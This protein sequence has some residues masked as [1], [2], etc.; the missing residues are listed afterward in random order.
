MSRLRKGNRFIADEASGGSSGESS[1]SESSDN[2]QGSIGT[3]IQEEVEGSDD[4]CNHRQVDNE[5]EEEDDKALEEDGHAWEQELKAHLQNE[6]GDE[7]GDSAEDIVERTEAKEGF[8]PTKQS[9]AVHRL[10]EQFV[11]IMKMKYARKAR[12][13]AKFPDGAVWYSREELESFVNSSGI[14]KVDPE[15]IKARE[16]FYNTRVAALEKSAGSS[17]QSHLHLGSLHD[18]VLRR[19]KKQQKSPE[20]KRKKRRKQRENKSPE[21][22]RKKRRKQR[23]NKKKKQGRGGNANE[24]KMMSSTK[25]E[26]KSDQSALQ[27]S[28]H[29]RKAQAKNALKG[30]GHLRKAQAKKTSHKHKRALAQA[31]QEEVQRR[32]DKA[33]QTLLDM[34]A[35]QKKEQ[36]G[37]KLQEEERPVEHS[38]GDEECSDGGHHGTEK[39][40]SDDGDGGGSV[41][42]SGGGHGKSDDGLQPEEKEKHEGDQVK[43]R[44]GEDAQDTDHYSDDG[45]QPEEKEQHER[46]QGQVRI[47]EDAQDTD[48]YSDVDDGR[49]P[50]EKGEHRK[51]QQSRAAYATANRKLTTIT[52]SNQDLH[53]VLTSLHE[54]KVVETKEAG[55]DITYTGVQRDVASALKRINECLSMPPEPG[56]GGPA[57]SYVA[58]PSDCQEGL[59]LRRLTLNH[60]QLWIC[61]HCEHKTINKVPVFPSFNTFPDECCMSDP[62]ML[63]W[64]GETRSDGR[65]HSCTLQQLVTYYFRDEPFLARCPQLCGSGEQIEVTQRQEL[66]HEEAPAFI[67]MSICRTF[68]SNVANAHRKIVREVH[69][70]SAVTVPI[71]NDAG[72]YQDVPYEIVSFVNHIG[73]NCNRGHY[74]SYMTTPARGDG[75]IYYIN[76]SKVTAVTRKAAYQ[77]CREGLRLIVLRCLRNTQPNPFHIYARGMRDVGASSFSSS[78]QSLSSSSTS[79]CMRDVVTCSSSSSSHSLSNSVSA[80][81][82][83]TGLPNQLVQ[84]V[85][86]SVSQAKSHTK[87]E[88]DSSDASPALITTPRK[89]DQSRTI[90][91]SSSSKSSLNQVG[92]SDNVDVDFTLDTPVRAQQPH[93]L[94]PVNPSIQRYA[95]SSAGSK[96]ANGTTVTDREWCDVL[97]YYDSLPKTNP[98]SVKQMEGVKQLLQSA[99]LSKCRFQIMQCPIQ[100]DYSYD[101]FV[102]M[103]AIAVSLLHGRGPVREDQYAGKSS[104]V[105]RRH[106]LRCL[107]KRHFTPFEDAE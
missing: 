23:E 100:E 27:G 82:S 54:W 48:Q 81:A 50:E 64:P 74:V 31:R 96:K 47:G 22:K 24:K 63:S 7:V 66:C 98:A 37:R 59:P 55:S 45:R 79:V 21:Q 29:L 36:T 9:A 30:S 53:A 14:L 35:A 91:S 32:V 95:I 69:V 92:D 75:K 2:E 90:G 62:L 41:R 13:N 51:N 72:V 28:G 77:H 68:W 97:H 103:T 60:R 33:A 43:V 86:R 1:G 70:S 44:I 40:D 11:D 101:C 87:S 94:P 6:S 20:Q 10:S 61:P 58:K 38:S 17:V 52:A 39:E 106:L 49:Q 83:A 57:G 85:T 18:K 88:L 26:E 102:F 46:N 76:D 80:G 5:Q 107:L 93:V 25:K 73:D 65:G 15:E 42:D 4:S 71:A 105:M 84:A 19:R 34:W 3:F 99:H 89:A 56:Q 12:K 16:G 78:S 8:E 104:E 67:V